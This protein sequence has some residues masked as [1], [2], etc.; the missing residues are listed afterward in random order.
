MNE[1]LL[2][3]FLIVGSFLVKLL[4]LQFGNSFLREGVTKYVGCYLHG[5]GVE[6][7]GDPKQ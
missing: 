6:G 1:F 2:N 4:V 5:L 3:N 7:R